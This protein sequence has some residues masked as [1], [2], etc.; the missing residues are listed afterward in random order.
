[1]HRRSVRCVL[2]LAVTFFVSRFSI[3]ATTSKEFDLK[4]VFRHALENTESSQKAQSQLKGSEEGLSQARGAF[5]PTINLGAGYTWLDVPTNLSSSTKPEQKT[6][7]LNLTQPLFKG[8]KEYAGFRKAESAV[9]LAEQNISEAE[10]KLALDVVEVFYKVLSSEKDLQDLEQLLKLSEQRAKEL[11]SR[12]Q[13]GK[14]KKSDFLS[15]QVQVE[16]L[17]AQVEIAKQGLSEVRDNFAMITGLSR[18]AILKDSADLPRETQ[19]LE[20]VLLNLENRPDFK[21]QK[22]KILQ[23]EET[24]AI[25]R[26]GHFPTLDLSGNYYFDRPGTLADSKWDLGLT[27]TIPI[28]QGGVVQSQV[29]E[30]SESFKQAELDLAKLKRSARTEAQQLF[31]QLNSQMKASATL[32]RALSLAEENYKIQQRDYQLGLVTNLEVLQVFN[33]YV[34][35]L[36]QADRMRFSTK[37]T[38]MKFKLVAGEK[39]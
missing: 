19:G 39:L 38:Y 9:R 16:S 35:S 37:T 11:K 13:V 17:N 8:T 3:A 21:V 25:A 28:F 32:D 12:Y 31:D 4:S 20:Q 15:A 27:L 18:D 5:F 22:E 7:K 10:R 26:G 14:S 1:M 24:V 2:F 29:R 6:V 36:R 23:A 34:E 30:A 33:S